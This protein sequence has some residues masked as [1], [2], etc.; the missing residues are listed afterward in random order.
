MDKVFLGVKNQHAVPHCPFFPRTNG[1]SCSDGSYLA[2]KTC[3][4]PRTRRVVAHAPRR[5]RVARQLESRPS[6]D[7]STVRVGM[8]SIK[9][10]EGATSSSVEEEDTAGP[11]VVGNSML[12]AV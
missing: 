12:L 1:A 8:V 10:S 11:I 7:W 9:D 4:P 5:G 2:A 6:Q 3:W